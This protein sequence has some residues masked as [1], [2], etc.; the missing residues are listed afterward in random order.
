MRR[1]RCAIL[2]AVLAQLDGFPRA[3]ISAFSLPGQPAPCRGSATTNCRAGRSN[4]AF[5]SLMARAKYNLVLRGDSPSSRRLYDGIAA[6]AVSVLVSD[7]LWS[8]GLPFTCLIPWRKMALTLS[9]RPFVTREGA[10]STLHALDALSPNLLARM[11]RLAN[12]HRRDLL[13][14]INGSR[15][16][17]NLLITSA[18]RCL[19][20][21]VT[22]RAAATRTIERLRRL[23]PHG[24][25]SI[26]CRTPDAQS[27]AGCETG[28]LAPSTLI[29]HCC[30]DSCPLC[31]RSASRCMPSDV[32]YGDPL[33][34][35][36]SRRER[37][38]SYLSQKDRNASAEMQQWRKLVGRPKASLR[39]GSPRGSNPRDAHAMMRQ[40]PRQRMRASPLATPNQNPSP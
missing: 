13:W 29:E 12:R 4:P 27:C 5:R 26:A 1:A 37:L 24:D 3:H 32:Y 15:V 21:H 6:G 39:G 8:V 38:D 40:K 36:P 35:A 25:H 33:G 34:A 31:N 17:E 10:A 19:P 7:E 9:E 11:Q 23:C 18:L 14:N 20:S 22:R 28:D 30:A 2:P 16:A